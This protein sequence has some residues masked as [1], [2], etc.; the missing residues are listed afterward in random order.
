VAG[1]SLNQI[2]I[3]V[4]KRLRMARE[5]L[6]VTQSECAE[7]ISMDRSTL[8]NY[9]STRSPVRWE[10]ALRFCRQWIISE[11]WLATGQFQACH[12]AAKKR[13][14]TPDAEVEKLIFRR[15]CMDLLSEP[16][17]R[18]IPGGILFT[19]AYKDYL[20]PVYRQL[21]DRFFYSPRIILHE[22]DNAEIGINLLKAAMER[23]VLLLTNEAR[24]CAQPPGRVRRSFY[25][26]IYEATEL[27][28][29][30][31]LP[32]PPGRAESDFIASLDWLRKACSDPSVKLGPL[33]AVQSEPTFA[34]A[35]PLEVIEVKE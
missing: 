29:L 13:G 32:F 5:F 23:A 19:A 25:R 3:A 21:V 20:A 11:E 34:E 6:G 10:F 28:A 1:K 7:Q 4:C 22:T 2:E 16:I 35:E 15:Q 12:L 8:V 17:T 30:K 26:A 14:Q 9:E 33:N 31:F 18:T 24:R 27:I